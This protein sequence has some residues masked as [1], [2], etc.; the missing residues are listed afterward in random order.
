MHAT[1]PDSI[2]FLS[3]V[4][5]FYLFCRFFFFLPL[6]DFLDVCCFLL[7]VFIPSLDF[8]VKIVSVYPTR[9]V[10][11]ETTG[12]I[13]SR[14]LNML[15]SSNHNRRNQYGEGSRAVAE[16]PV[17]GF[18]AS[19]WWRHARYYVTPAVVLDWTVQESVIHTG[20]STN[21]AAGTPNEPGWYRPNH[22]T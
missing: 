1:R 12:W 8:L 14:S 11:L 20:R 15:E 7:H 5:V 19:P 2:L 10:Y 6:P 21:H 13:R 16:G 4:F 18:S 17:R 9:H 3:L 22:H